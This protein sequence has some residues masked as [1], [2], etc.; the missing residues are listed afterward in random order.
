MG[1]PG[2]KAD[3]CELGVQI[4]TTLNFITPIKRMRTHR[5]GFTLT[6]GLIKT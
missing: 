4:N 1:W 3:S 6:L 2:D 5:N